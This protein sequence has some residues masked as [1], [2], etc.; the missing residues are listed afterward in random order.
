[1]LWTQG[2][3]S[4][5]ALWEMRGCQCDHSSEGKRHVPVQTVL[6]QDGVN[7]VRCDMFT[8]GPAGHGCRAWTRTPQS[9]RVT[10]RY[11]NPPHNNKGVGFSLNTGV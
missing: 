6:L 10:T 8:K 2:R 11:S 7:A 5:P 3:C 1:V 9:Q 4:E